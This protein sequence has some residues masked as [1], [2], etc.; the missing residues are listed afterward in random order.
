MLLNCQFINYLQRF[1][2]ALRRRRISLSLLHRSLILRDIIFL[3]FLKI[4]LILTL[5]CF[6]LKYLFSRSFCNFCW[7]KF[8][9][10]YVMWLFINKLRLYHVF[11]FIHLFSSFLG[12][13][14]LKIKL[15]L[16]IH[17]PWLISE[18]LDYLLSL[19]MYTPFTEA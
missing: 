12:L 6:I 2:Q 4:W 11:A 17:V 7:R 18:V 10:L 1:H 5:I 13:P 19:W 16:L 9:L 14:T 8:H 3:F 15:E